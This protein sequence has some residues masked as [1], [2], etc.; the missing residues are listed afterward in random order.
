MKKFVNLFLALL[1]CV[2]LVTAALYAS[3]AAVKK[4]PN[5]NPKPTA[6]FILPGN[7]DGTHT[8]PP[9]GETETRD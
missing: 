5:P 4:G 8:V 2:C 3:G 6:T 7:P 1:L 9:G